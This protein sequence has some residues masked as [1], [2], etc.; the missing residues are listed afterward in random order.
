MVSWL[1]NKKV[2][3]KAF[4]D[5]ELG[6]YFLSLYTDRSWIIRRV[7]HISMLDL[8][9]VERR[10]SVDLDL[11]VLHERYM[12]VGL[13]KHGEILVPFGLLEKKPHLDFDVQANRWEPSAAAD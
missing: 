2:S 7:E 11:R 13:P 8:S 5:D 12:E 4:D 6:D 3:E 10:T 9:R 1:W